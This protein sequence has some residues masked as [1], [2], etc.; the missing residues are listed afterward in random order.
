MES[1]S[2]EPRTPS[3]NDPFPPSTSHDDNDDVAT[4]IEYYSTDHEDEDDSDDYGEDS[5]SSCENYDNVGGRRSHQP[6]HHQEATHR[7]PYLQRVTSR[8]QSSDHQSMTSTDAFSLPVRAQGEDEE[9]SSLEENDPVDV[10]LHYDSTRNISDS[11]KEDGP[12]YNEVDRVAQF[13]SPIGVV[14]CPNQEHLI[15]TVA[16]DAAIRSISALPS[17]PA[18][19]LLVGQPEIVLDDEQDGSTQ[20]LHEVS[21]LRNSVSKEGILRGELNG[22]GTDDADM[23][24]LTQRLHR[25]LFV[26]QSSFL[27]EEGTLEHAS[28]RQV[29]DDLTLKEY[30]KTF[31]PE[32]DFE[33]AQ[34]YLLQLAEGIPDTLSSPRESTSSELHHRHIT[35]P[36]SHSE[37][38]EIIVDNEDEDIQR[39]PRVASKSSNGRGGSR[40]DCYSPKESVLSYDYTEIVVESWEDEIIVEEIIEE[41]EAY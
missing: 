28:G 11:L 40:A 1:R 2:S 8:G 24:D 17:L 15:A 29:M 35:T 38:T 36:G 22:G 20:S 14:S 41:E 7:D 3:S 23:E 26:A 16:N 30:A 18:A 5:S 33:Q 37:Y 32:L 31:P 39:D 25:S 19:T 13:P 9:M 27:Y 6:I 12:D 34:K 10:G 4:E 21:D